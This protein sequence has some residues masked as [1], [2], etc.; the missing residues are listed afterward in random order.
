MNSWI[1]AK[2]TMSSNLRSISLLRIPRIAPLRKTFSRP[3]RSG[4]KPVPTSSSDPTRPS[5]STVP[6]VGSTMRDRILSRVLF[7]DPLRPMIP[8]TSP[9]TTSN[10][11]SSSAQNRAAARRVP[12]RLI[13]R[14]TPSRLPTSASRRVRYLARAPSWYCFPRCETRMTRDASCGIGA[15]EC[16]AGN[17][18]SDDIGE[19]ALHASE[20]KGTPGEERERGDTRDENHRARPRRRPQ[21]RPA[22]SLDD[23]DHRVQRVQGAPSLGQQ[24]AGIGDGRREHPELREEGH[25]VSNVSKLDVERRE[26]EADAERGREGQRDEHRKPYDL[27]GGC[28]SVPPH[29]PEQHREREREINEAG[30][31][32]GERDRQSREIHLRDEVG[33]SNEAVRRQRESRREERPRRERSVGEQWV[34]NA[35]GRYMSEASE[36]EREH[37]H[38]EQ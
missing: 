13:S 23:A 2:R 1:S 3:V 14:A 27:R 4:W 34:G 10:E 20:E 19:R 22:E 16:A 9:W 8:T 24:A 17:A 31:H 12:P 28:D 29:E 25:H 33:A 6:V 30:E 36:K 15:R 37:E 32:G 18:T 35:V 38:R 11:T 5:R 26:P 21:Q 7:P